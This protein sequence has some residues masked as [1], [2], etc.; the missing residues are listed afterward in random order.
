MHEL[1]FLLEP[2]RLIALLF[3]SMRTRNYQSHGVPEGHLTM[4]KNLLPALPRRQR[5]RRG[6]RSP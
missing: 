1:G 2:I 6:C 3:G 4:S 5:F